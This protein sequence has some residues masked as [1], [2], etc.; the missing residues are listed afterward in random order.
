MYQLTP[1]LVVSASVVIFALWLWIFH[2]TRDR[3]GL[4]VL[5]TIIML[6]GMARCLYILNKLAPWFP[7][8]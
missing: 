3:P 7:T 8:H 2:T 4:F 6:L 5:G 1:S